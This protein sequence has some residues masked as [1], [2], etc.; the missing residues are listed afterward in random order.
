MQLGRTY[1]YKIK[2]VGTY[3][4]PGFVNP[5]INFSQYTCAAPKD[6]VP[7][8]AVAD[9]AAANCDE[10]TSTIEWTITQPE[11]NPDVVAYKIYFS[12]RRENKF[13][14]VDSIQSSL[15]KYKDVR[16]ILRNSLAGCYYVSAVD[17]FGNESPPSNQSCVDN[18]PVYN[19]PNVFTPGTD[20]KN[21]LYEPMG[22]Y[23]FIQSV[24]MHI[25]NRWGMEVFK[26]SDPAIKWDGRDMKTGQPVAAGTYFFICTVKEIF[27]DEIKATSPIEGTITIIR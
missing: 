14:L 24:D 25:F 3:G 16:D 11:C 26:T 20:G 22:D 15:L 7:P 27:L 1:C 17:S 9:S 19:L 8:C 21:D 5:I 18:C 12:N 13:I 10:R 4:S 6:T 2:S 23:R